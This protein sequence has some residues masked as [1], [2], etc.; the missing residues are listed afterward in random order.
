MNRILLILL[1]TSIGAASLW[2]QGRLRHHTATRA[3]TLR[4]VP[5]TSP[6]PSEAR[7]EI[8]K[9]DGSRVIKANGI[10]RHQVG[11]FPNPGNPNPIREQSY[12]IEFP[13]N[14]AMAPEIIPLMMEGRSLEVFGITLDGVFFEPHANEFWQRDWEWR[15]EALGAAIELGL[16]ANHGHVQ[17]TGLYHY[18]GIP[19]GLMSRLGHVPGEHSPLIGWAA[20]GFPIYARHGYSDPRDPESAVAD[21]SPSYRLREGERPSPPVGPGGRPDGAFVRDYEYIAGS[22]DLD[23]CNGRFCV[24]PDFPEGTYA[25]FLT[26]D[27]PVIP[28]AFRGEPVDLKRQAGLRGP[29]RAGPG[30]GPPR[31]PKGPPRPGGKGARPL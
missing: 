28:R 10:P 30:A 27:W 11:A 19:T 15:Y 22:G 5:A 21:L 2:A 7:V 26:R 1:I 4:L 18:H 13:E 12:V 20:D 9:R 24:T 3:G 17:P 16:D 23:E 8:E 14:P 31:G 25:Y 29:G 6:T